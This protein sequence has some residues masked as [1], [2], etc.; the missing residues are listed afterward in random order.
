MELD[1]KTEQGTLV[2]SYAIAGGNLKDHINYLFHI[3]SNFNL[4]MVII[5]NAGYQFIDSAN[6]SKLFKEANV[7]INFFD[8]IQNI[9][10][11]I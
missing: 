6:A 11:A 5:D 10:L 7:K 9:F 1:D 8:F 2:H 3:V 4:E